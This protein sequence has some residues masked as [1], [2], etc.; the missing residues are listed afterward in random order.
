MLRHVLDYLPTLTLEE[1]R[2]V[3]RSVCSL[4]RGEHVARRERSTRKFQE[5]GHVLHQG[6]KL[7]VQK[8]DGN[9]VIVDGNVAIPVSQCRPF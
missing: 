2:T 7:R 9:R 5:G 3:N 8:L 6:Q 4:I 1:L